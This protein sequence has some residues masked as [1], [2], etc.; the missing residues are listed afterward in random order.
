MCVCV[1][2]C[3]CVFVCVCV[4]VCMYVYV[5]MYKR[6]YV[7]MYVCMYV[8]IYVYVCMYVLHTYVCMHIYMY[9]YISV[10]VCVC[11][12]VCVYTDF[13]DTRESPHDS[14]LLIDLGG[15]RE[16]GIISKIVHVED[17]SPSLWCRILKFWGVN[18][19]KVE[20]PLAKHLKNQCP[21]IPT[22]QRSYKEYFSEFV[23]QTRA[24]D[25][26]GTGILL[27]IFLY[28]VCLFLRV[29]QT[30]AEDGGDTR[31]H[32]DHMLSIN[33]PKIQHPGIQPSFQR[34]THTPSPLNP[35]AISHLWDAP[36]HVLRTAGPPPP[37]RQP[38]PPQTTPSFH[39][40]YAP[41]SGT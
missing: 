20:V 35:I 28:L 33:T 39:H 41:R 1:C 27:F 15:L 6:V 16:G 31:A 19:D 25:R 34:D 26:S 8:C 11:V 10:C 14:H 2:V 32:A 21:S 5:C 17:G 23:F 36:V 29:H 24:P 37:L 7:C 13:I 40:C 3:V 30:R 22:M 12:C 18:F 9:V 38:P 4:C